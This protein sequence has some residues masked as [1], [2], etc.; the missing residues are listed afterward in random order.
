[1]NLGIS[2]DGLRARGVALDSDGKV[3]SRAEPRE[4]TGLGGVISE[5]LQ[6]KSGIALESIGLAF[7][8]P[9]SSTWKMPTIETD[10]GG[11]V[12]VHCISSGNASVL[13]EMK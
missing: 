4:L 12:P 13:A 1:M 6:A 9:D 11:D 5:I 10:G 8:D 3:V 2:F 7:P